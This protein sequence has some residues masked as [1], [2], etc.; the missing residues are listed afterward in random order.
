[1][2]A[3]MTDSPMPLNQAKLKVAREEILSVLK[4]HDIAGFCVL[5][6]PGWAEVFWDM[7]PSY[8]ILQGDF[9]SVRFKSKRSDYPSADA[10]LYDQANTAQMLRALGENAAGPILQFVELSKHADLTLGAT[11]E[12]LGFQHDPWK[13][14]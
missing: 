5:H 12:D 4:K 6:S 10:Q 7:W 13:K 14:D 2:E 9:P 11:H 8:S 1:M 3:Y